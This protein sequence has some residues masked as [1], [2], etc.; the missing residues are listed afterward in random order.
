MSAQLRNAELQM[1]EVAG[2]SMELRREIDRLRRENLRLLERMRSMETRLAE[3]LA[4]RDNPGPG[5]AATARQ[6]DATPITPAP[7]PM[8]P[9]NLPSTPGVQEQLGSPAPAS[10][11][12]ESSLPKFSSP[13]LSKRDPGEDA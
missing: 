4:R 13:R 8:T 11:S 2:G 6:P 9:P 7:A 1:H 3:E 5:I 12:S 10:D